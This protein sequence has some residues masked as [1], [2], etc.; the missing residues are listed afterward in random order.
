MLFIL[1]IE[2]TCKVYS[3]KQ[4]SLS[5]RYLGAM[6]GEIPQTQET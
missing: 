2:A 4:V 5:K 3:A 1:V 6:T